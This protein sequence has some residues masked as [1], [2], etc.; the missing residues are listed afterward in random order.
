MD[1][2]Q[3]S[4]G[5]YTLST[6]FSLLLACPN[7]PFFSAPEPVLEDNVRGPDPSISESLRRNASESQWNDTRPVNHQPVP[8][9][10]SRSLSTAR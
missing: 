3:R 5:H 1:R 6:K 9:G 7:L 10:Q 4:A 8:L 2:Y